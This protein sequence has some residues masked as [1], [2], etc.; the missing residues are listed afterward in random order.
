MSVKPLSRNRFL[1]FNS[2]Q[3]CFAGAYAQVPGKGSA[4][5]RRAIFRKCPIRHALEFPKPFVDAVDVDVVRANPGSFEGYD[6][7]E[8]NNGTAVADGGK[9]PGKIF[10]EKAFGGYEVIGG[11]DPLKKQAAQA[12]ADGLAHQQSARK[13]RDSGRNTGY[14]GQVGSPVINQVT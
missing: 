1:R 13:H 9:C 11:A 12:F 7:F 2:E 10:A 5:K 14:D 8:M 4:D 3:Y 6:A